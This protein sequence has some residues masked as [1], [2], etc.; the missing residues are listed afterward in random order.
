MGRLSWSDISRDPPWNDSVYCRQFISYP[1]FTVRF[2]WDRRPRFLRNFNSS[3]AASGGMRAM[4][5]LRLEMQRDQEPRASAC[6]QRWALPKRQENHA[7]QGLR[8]PYKSPPECFLSPHFHPHTRSAEHKR[9]T[10][11]VEH[12]STTLHL[13]RLRTGIESRSYRYRTDHG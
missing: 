8:R 12:I 5:W 13:S 10:S 2:T 1:G 9:L 4:L 7:Q 6:D 11:V 3:L